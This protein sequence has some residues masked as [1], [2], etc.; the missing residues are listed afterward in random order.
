MASSRDRYADLMRQGFMKPAP[1]GRKAR[2]KRPIVACERCQD[3]HEEGRH[4]RPAAARQTRESAPSSTPATPS[5]HATYEIRAFLNSVQV[6]DL[7]HSGGSRLL[8][9]LFSPTI[10]PIPGETR[11]DLVVRE[12][13]KLGTT[14]PSAAEFRPGTTYSGRTAGSGATAS[15]TKT[16]S[17]V[18]FGGSE[19][20][21][22]YDRVRGSR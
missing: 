1:R 15:V 10:M 3:W 13:R 16:T 12:L 22:I 19:Q 20:Q 7:E 8:Q 11:A 14:T 4:R 5:L 2:E 17:L 9:R 21:A 6:I 18:G